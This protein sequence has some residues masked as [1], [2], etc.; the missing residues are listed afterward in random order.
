MAYCPSCGKEAEA[1]AN[2]CSTCG[3]R[4]SQA[5]EQIRD[6]RVAG[7]RASERMALQERIRDARIGENVLGFLGFLFVTI[8][9]VLMILV[10]LDIL[11]DFVFLIGLVSIFVGLCL[12]IG[13][14][15]Y[16]FQKKKLIDEL[17]RQR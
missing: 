16:Y 11:L 4:L 14:L 15:I 2:F 13:S 3:A 9:G 12:A 17:K 6:T 7:N 1:G 8:G 10:L 5:S